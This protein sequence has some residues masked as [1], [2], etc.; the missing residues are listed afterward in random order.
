MKKS[1]L[2]ILLSLILNSCATTKQYKKFTDDKPLEENMARVYLVRTGNFG[3]FVRFNS[4]LDT[5]DNQVG[6]VGPKSYLC[7]DTP[8]GEHKVIVKAETERF[9]TINAQAGK[10]YYLRLVPKMGFNYARVNFELLSQEEGIKE[11]NRLKSPK[12]YYTE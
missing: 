6:V 9:Y 10:I 8:I 3:G 11:V 1:I 2:L 4:Y 12:M 7:F 5:T